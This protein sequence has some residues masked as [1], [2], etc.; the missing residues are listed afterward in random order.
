MKFVSLPKSS[1]GLDE[2]GWAGVLARFVPYTQWL[3]S[4]KGAQVEGLGAERVR[5][6]LKADRKQ[7]LLDL[8]KKDRALEQESNS[9]DD[10]KKLMLLYRDYAKLLNNYLI[11][12][13][14]YARSDGRRAIFEAGKLYI[15]QRCCDLCIRVSDMARHADMV[16]L[17]GMFLIYCKCTSKLLGKTMDIVAVMTDGDISELRPGKNGV[18]YDC[19]GRDWD[20]T[21]TK[22]VDNPVSIK[23]AFWSPY[24]KF[25]E[26]CVGLI[27]KSA[28]DKDA[29]MM[30]EMQAK[31]SEAA[32]SA[33]AAVTA[34]GTPAA[35]ASRKQPFD[36]AK[37]AGIFAALGLALG[38]IGSFLT[39]LAAGIA[40]TPWWQL[41]LAVAV[42]M[43]IISGPSCFIAWSK[44]RRRNLGPVLNANG[45]AINSKV[46][47]NIVFGAKLTSVAQYPKLRIA[48]PDALK[49]SS[50][51]KWLI[52]V[53]ALALVAAAVLHIVGIVDLGIV[54][55]SF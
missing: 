16:K 12:S 5:A 8:V 42:I 14:F 53:L 39:K 20:A 38:Y 44:L 2:A 24:R 46:L 23:Q 41:L 9:I 26:F 4:K 15:D 40:A 51:W 7:Y 21:V 49:P 48:D 6:I 17:S 30:S 55:L 18:F 31:A 34:A 36:I 3:E 29:K 35:D 19:A 43:L 54:W 28:A 33:P 32:K 37:F 13:D 45:W 10:V 22:V 27:N 1:K 11:F 25:W 47:V 52:A 50:W